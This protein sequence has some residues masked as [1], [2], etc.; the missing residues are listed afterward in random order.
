MKKIFLLIYLYILALKANLVVDFEASST[1]NYSYLP[2]GQI[3]SDGE[4]TYTYDKAGRSSRIQRGTVG[5]LNQ[6]DPF[7][8]HVKKTSGT[9]ISYFVYDESG[10]LLG[11]YDNNGLRI[12]EDAWLGERVVTVRSSQLVNTATAPHPPDRHVPKNAMC[13]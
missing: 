9:V 5:I 6:Y 8:Q 12:R 13:E 11:E 2:T 10:H 1:A 4:R 7:G 3:S